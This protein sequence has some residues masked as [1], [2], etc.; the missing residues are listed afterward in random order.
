MLGVDF[1][2]DQDEQYAFSQK[3]SQSNNRYLHEDDMLKR[4]KPH[5]EEKDIKIFNCNPDSKCTAFDYVS[6]DDAFKQC[7]NGVPEN[8]DL[9]NWYEKV[10]N[11][12]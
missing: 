3:A 11:P 4:I 9:S 1:W 8:I 2:R 10:D 12:N 6:F 7:K 5:L